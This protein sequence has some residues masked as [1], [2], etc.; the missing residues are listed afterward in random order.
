[1]SKMRAVNFQAEHLE[2]VELCQEHLN[3]YGLFG[4][5]V[6][7]LARL[8][9]VSATYTFVVDDRPVGL[10]GLEHIWKGVGRVWLALSDEAK[11]HSVAL[12]K[13]TKTLMWTVVKSWKLH[14][15]E[16]VVRAGYVAGARFAR[17]FG[18][19]SEARMAMYGPDGS[20]FF[21]VA[22]TFYDNIPGRA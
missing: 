9:K 10:V 2:Q 12:V 3:I 18:F 15:I 14:R 21:L 16:G 5:P 6:E 8:V 19:V 20:D 4:P 1:M 17:H 7:V 13:W 22:R 11:Q